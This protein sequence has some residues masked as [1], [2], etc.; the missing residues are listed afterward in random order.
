MENSM[1]KPLVFILAVCSMLVACNKPM[2]EDDLNVSQAE[3]AK[4]VNKLN[5]RLAELEIEL[6]TVNQQVKIL[7]EAGMTVTEVINPCGDQVGQYDEV[8]IK[9]SSGQVVAFFEHGD[10]RF[11]SIL[12]NGTYRTTDQQGCLF[13]INDGQISY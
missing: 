6:E 9:L 8:L 2:S 7:N 3:T 10:K 11:L 12:D 1:I 5:D 13:N 4:Q